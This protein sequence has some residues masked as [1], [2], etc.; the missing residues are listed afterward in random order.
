M[1]KNRLINTY[2]IIVALLLASCECNDCDYNY[3]LYQIENKLDSPI[4]VRFVSDSYP[5][6]NFEI[7]INSNETKD[8]ING[9]SGLEGFGLR[10][11]DSAF[12]K[13]NSSEYSYQRNPAVGLL[14]S[15]LYLDNGIS[16]KNGKILRIYKLI[17]DEEFLLKS[18]K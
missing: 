11:Y 1:R 12:L 3:L 16:K 2:L 5:A 18:S 15:S 7:T 17:V 6:K 9:E 13:T 10:S 8:I 14:S 4:Q